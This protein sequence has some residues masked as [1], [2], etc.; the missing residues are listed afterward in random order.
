VFSF[1]P[2][3][4]VI[5]M[6]SGSPMSL[7]YYGG[8]NEDALRHKIL[9]IQEAAMLADRHGVESPLT[10][11]VRALIS[12][13]H[14]DHHVAVPQGKGPPVDEHIRRNGPTTVALTSARDNI[15]SELLTRL[16][17]SD[18]NETPGQT[19]SIVERLWSDKDPEPPDRESWVNFQRLLARDAPYH[20]SVPFGAAMYAALQEWAKT[21]PTAM[22]VRMRRDAGSL[23]SAIKASAVIHK[24]KRARDARGRLV[25]TLDDYAVAHS[26]F[27]AGVS[28]L[29]GLKPTVAL[30]AV[31]QAI[32]DMGATKGG[33][34]IK[35]TVSSLR[36][37]I[38]V[39]SNDVA[40]RRLWEAVTLG[41]LGFDDAKSGEGRG[42]PNWFKLI[43]TAK[44][45]E[46]GRQKGVFP[47]PETVAAVYERFSP[48]CG[49]GRQNGQNGQDI[50]NVAKPSTVLSGDGRTE[51][52]G[53]PDESEPDAVLSGEGKKPDGQDNGSESEHFGGQD[54]SSSVLSVLSVHPAT[55]KTEEN[56]ADAIAAYMAGRVEASFAPD[57]LF[58]AVGHPLT[59]GE[60]EEI[61][62]DVLSLI[63]DDLAERGI[64]IRFEHGHI[65]LG[66]AWGPSR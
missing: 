37:A 50:Q 59:N 13:G 16:L 10:I 8:G 52:E 60:D 20:V 23:L 53:E 21:L 18:A 36:A 41:F 28:A 25:A 33:D 30:V 35:V 48:Q 38:G 31:V 1:F 15:E 63:E 2:D 12:E 11:M 3:E 66:H 47:P 55:R 46:A 19:M 26:A 57:R 61:A 5:H 45:I 24:A 54:G 65:V 32:E 44:E 42:K 62:I 4:D 34:A 39:N 14:V 43:S 64:E 58:A 27:D 7:V 22:Q 56:F 51:Q 40:S 9:Y 6:S 49:T 17:T 29:Y